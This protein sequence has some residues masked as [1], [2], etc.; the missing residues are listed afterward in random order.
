MRAATAANGVKVNAED[1]S[2]QA[3]DLRH[4]AILLIENHVI[5]GAQLVL[6]AS[7]L[8][9]AAA[10]KVVDLLGDATVAL[11]EPEDRASP[12]VYTVDGLRA[13]MDYDL[14][15]DAPDDSARAGVDPHEVDKFL[16]W[17]Q[18]KE[19]QS[20]QKDTGNSGRP[21]TGKGPNESGG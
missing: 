13:L 12:C 21:D 11:D 10:D 19:Q 17:L 18:T 14:K 3:S 15:H 4:T 9:S 6:E 16:D 7:K 5:E 20:G 2:K 8:L 1:I